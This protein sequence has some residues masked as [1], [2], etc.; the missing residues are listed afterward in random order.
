VNAPLEWSVRRFHAMGSDAH[1]LVRS[2]NAPAL[3]R[4]AVREVERLEQSWSRFRRDS[5]LMVLNRAA[6]TGWVAVTDLLAFAL[7]RARAAYELT[8]GYFDP[9]VHGALV[10]L[11]YDRTFH[12]LPATPPVMTTCRAPGFN[13]VTFDDSAPGARVA[14]PE[15]VTLDLGGIGKGL[16]VDVVVDGL[17]ARGASSICVSLGGDLRVAGVG[18]DPDGSW[19][20]EVEDPKSGRDWFRFALV[21]EAIA[22]STVALRRWRDRNGTERHHLVDP[23]S[24]ASAESGITSVVVTTRDAWQADVLAKAVLISGRQG[25]LELLDRARADGWLFA[26]DGEVIATPAVA[27]VFPAAS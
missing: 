10:A 5:D 19:E 22:Q 25:G 27:D 3:A 20:V 13:L 6:G 12:D 26:A 8:N 11:G 15:G 9:T 14:L 23:S 21:D 24:G 16:A 18:P 2:T 17:L 1:V 7:G 4:W